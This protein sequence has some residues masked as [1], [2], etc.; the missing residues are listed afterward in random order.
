M[1]NKGIA[2]SQTVGKVNRLIR[3]EGAS[4][5]QRQRRDRRDGRKE[6]RKY[7]K[8]EGRQRMGDKVG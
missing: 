6:G 3:V 7:E 1:H 8:K 5:G 2:R 4:V